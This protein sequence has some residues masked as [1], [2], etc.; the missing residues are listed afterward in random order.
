MARP[1]EGVIYN[2]E[3]K[4]RYLEWKEKSVETNVK[5]I[6]RLFRKIS[7]F[8]FEAG[9]DVSLFNPFE[10]NNLFYRIDTSSLNVLKNYKSSLS[11]Y[12]DWCIKMNLTNDSQ[13]YIEQL[14]IDTLI[15]YRNGLLRE[16]MFI[17]REE[18]LKAV[19]GIDF[20]YRYLLVAPFEGICGPGCMELRKLHVE[21]MKGNIVHLCT[22]RTITVSDEL[23]YIIRMTAEETVFAPGGRYRYELVGDPGLVLKPRSTVRTIASVVTVGTLVR[24]FNKACVAAGLPNELSIKR[25]SFNGMVSFIKVEADKEGVPVKEKTESREFLNQCSERFGIAINPHD[26]YERDLKQFFEK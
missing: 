4:N 8:E 23:A 10:L 20:V 15:I 6:D 21:D 16:Q 25:M 14:D 18:L 12:V 19:D 9:K 11:Q 24:M 17:S 22:G 13:N 26:F 3:I 2:P 5:T 1:R 7:P